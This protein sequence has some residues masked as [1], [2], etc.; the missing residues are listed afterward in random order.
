MRYFNVIYSVLVIN[1][2]LCRAERFSKIFETKTGHNKVKHKIL[3]MW[4]QFV[5][6]GYMG[7]KLKK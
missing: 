1:E 7:P 4:E 6:K 2:E 3:K 5:Q